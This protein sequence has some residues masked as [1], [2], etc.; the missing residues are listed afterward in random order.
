[1]K[2]IARLTLA[3][4]VGQLFMLG[5]QGSVPDAETDRVL[6]KVQPGGLVSFQRNIESLDQIYELNLEFQRS[7]P[8]PPLLAINQ[9]G[10]AIDRLKHVITPIPSVSDLADLGTPAVRTGARLLASELEACGFNMNLAPV[11]DLGLPRSVVRERTLAASAKEVTRLASVVLDEFE[12]K[13]VLAC[14]SHF[15]GLGGAERDPHFL[16]P[17]VDRSRRDLLAE[18]VV[19]F[20]ELSSRLGMIMVSH[21]HY[22]T[23]GDIRPIPASLS[24]RVINGLLRETVG[25]EG[26]VMTDDLT[27]GAVTSVGLSPRTF[28]RAI[29]AGNDMVLFSQAT[30]MLEEA[31]ELLVETARSDNAFQRR[32]DQSV[33]R[34]LHL[35]E[36]I[37]NIP[38]RSRARVKTRLMRQIEKLKQ[39]ISDVERIEVR[40]R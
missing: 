15:P 29:Q 26:V 10:G 28:L 27:M 37:E 7:L 21:G 1:M 6:A 25:F 39:S 8:V 14:G 12:K 22:P 33:E 3:Q 35:K 32:V 40:Q 38:L 16:L 19:P 30:P 18:D 11:L 20:N 36:R 31:F 13:R 34:I 5:F 24:S 17:R 4:R 9:E 2:D 23:L